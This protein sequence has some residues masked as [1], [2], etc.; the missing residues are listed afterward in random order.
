[1]AQ[2][3]SYNQLINYISGFSQSHQQ[4]MEF[5]NGFRGKINT[6][7]TSNNNFPLLFVEPLSH[8]YNN[9]VQTYTIRVYCMDVLQKD[10]SNETEVIS[11]TLQ[12]LNDLCKYIIDDATDEF[13]LVNQTPICIPYTNSYVDYLGGWFIDLTIT[14]RIVVGDCDIPLN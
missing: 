12:I 4:V 8:T 5:N 7:V 3:Q 1:M 14:V 13:D 6:A 11:D 9:W 10:L 2:Q